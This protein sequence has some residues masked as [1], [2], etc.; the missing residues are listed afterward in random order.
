M[1]RGLY[2]RRSAI[3]NEF[4]SVPHLSSL[5][6]LHGIANGL[7]GLGTRGPPCPFPFC[8]RRL[9]SSPHAGVRRP[10]SPSAKLLCA[11]WQHPSYTVPAP[12]RVPGHD[13]E[14]CCARILGRSI[15]IARY[16]RYLRCVLGE[17]ISARCMLVARRTYFEF[18][19]LRDLRGGSRAE[20]WQG[21][22]QHW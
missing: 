16:S 2:S 19:C 7:R 17:Q 11:L 12:I 20:P 21:I 14:R 18:P 15:W 3:I 9:S 10:P 22:P 13:D 4:P 6:R 5:Q 1:L 8:R